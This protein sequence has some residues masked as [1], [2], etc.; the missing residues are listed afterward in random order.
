MGLKSK[1][2]KDQ[3]SEEKYISEILEYWLF[4]HHLLYSL[5]IKPGPWCRK[6]SGV[7]GWRIA[8]HMFRSSR[9]QWS[10]VK[11]DP[12]TQNLFTNRAFQECNGYLTFKGWMSYF[13]WQDNYFTLYRR[14]NKPVKIIEFL[15]HW[16]SANTLKWRWDFK[17]KKY[18]CLLEHILAPLAL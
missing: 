4:W 17:K 10:E 1:W 16:P 11:G 13:F 18:T 14:I 6:L 12:L 2:Q 3:V 15:H 7:V 9:A 5:P 8:H